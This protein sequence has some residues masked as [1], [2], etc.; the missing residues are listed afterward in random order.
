MDI[1]RIR[2][3]L[4]PNKNLIL[5]YHLRQQ[6]VENVFNEKGC[7]TYLNSFKQFNAAH[8]ATQSSS[9]CSLQRVGF[10]EQNF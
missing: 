3:Q 7:E 9:A 2:V 4:H 6:R 10:A 8:I 1:C 5:V